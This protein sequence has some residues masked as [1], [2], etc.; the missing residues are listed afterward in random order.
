MAGPW[1]GQLEICQV[2]CYHMPA[3]VKTSISKISRD[4]PCPSSKLLSASNI[5]DWEHQM[6]SPG[7]TTEEGGL[8]AAS[9]RRD[10]KDQKI[11][12]WMKAQVKPRGGKARIWESNPADGKRL[13]EN[14]CRAA[15]LG[16]KCGQFFKGKIC[17]YDNVLVRLMIGKIFGPIQLICYMIQC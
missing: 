2:Q 1:L 10:N 14:W 5:T 17:W 6:P 15:D 11:R 13:K 16:S 3:T 7:G 12:R 9:F 8:A 4:P